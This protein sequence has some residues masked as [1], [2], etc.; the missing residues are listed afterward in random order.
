[1]KLSRMI[2]SWPQSLFLR[3][4]FTCN[5][6]ITTRCNLRCGFCGLWSFPVKRELQL[7]DYRHIAEMLDRLGIARVVITGGEPLLRDDAPEILSLFAKRGISTTLLTN[8]ILLTRDKLQRFIDS[9][10]NDIGVSLD[11]LDPD[12]IDLICQSKN[13]WQKIVD[14]IS[15]SVEM[16]NH[17]IVEV[18]ITVTRE[19]LLEVPDIVRFVDSSLG[20]WAL[21][22]PVNV[23]HSDKSI[24]AADVS[25]WAPPYPA[26]DVDA[27]YDELEKMKRKKLRLLVSDAFLNASRHYLKT[28]DFKWTCDAGER[29]FTIF[30]DGGLAPCSDQP[31]IRDVTKMTHKDF[32]ST[33]YRQDVR[34][35]QRECPGCIY[36]CWRE[37]SYLFS[38]RSVMLERVKSLGR[39]FKGRQM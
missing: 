32:R 2:Y 5:V 17:G 28:G 18:F 12:R 22:N 1:M 34:K 13:I 11:S 26:K 8:G 15:L 21:V 9:G 36:A 30:P 33:L 6:K 14:A 16:L 7:S 25:E 39:I 37:A 4:P 3:T 23:P 20:A 35:V 31:V 10:L 24:L 29:Y 27:V 38:D 19:N